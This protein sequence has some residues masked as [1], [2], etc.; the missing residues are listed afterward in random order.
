MIGYGVEKGVK[1]WKIR[2]S[3][4]TYWADQ[5][6]AKII[7]GKNCIGIESN[8]AYWATPILEPKKIVRKP[9]LA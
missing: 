8:T 7:R 4:G 1:Y 3:W 5:G 9:K 2:N 6:N